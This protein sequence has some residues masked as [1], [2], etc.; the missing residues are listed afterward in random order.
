M[1][2]QK[3]PCSC[4]DKGLSV[5]EGKRRWVFWRLNEWQSGENFST[6]ARKPALKLEGRKGKALQPLEEAAVLY[7][8]GTKQ[9]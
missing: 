6:S 4:T 7:K 2:E 8:L 5:A 3:H 9:S 1:Q